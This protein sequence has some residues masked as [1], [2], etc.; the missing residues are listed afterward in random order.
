VD[1]YRAIAEY[2]ARIF[3]NDRQGY[4]TVKTAL[5]RGKISIVRSLSTISARIRVLTEMAVV[6]RQRD[7]ID[8]SAADFFANSMVG[9][10]VRVAPCQR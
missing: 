1:R 6:G 5:E 4:R 8:P 2:V 7:A 3:G 9:P 10:A